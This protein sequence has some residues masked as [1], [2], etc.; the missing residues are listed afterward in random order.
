[1]M[2]QWSLEQP[3]YEFWTGFY[4]DRVL[5]RKM[6]GSQRWLISAWAADAIPRTVSVT[7]PTLG[8]IS[9]YAQPTGTLYDARIVSGV[10][11]SH[12]LTTAP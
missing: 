1:M 6:K 2:H 12:D 11:H 8:T 4:N 3:A 10:Q 9:V 7:I 5:A